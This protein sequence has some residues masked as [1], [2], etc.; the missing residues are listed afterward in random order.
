MIRLRAA[1]G[2]ARVNRSS[3]A[4]RA[5]PGSRMEPGVRARRALSWHDFTSDGQTKRA[6]CHA[7]AGRYGINTALMMCTM[8][9][10]A[11]MSVVAIP[12]ATSSF[13]VSV[14]PLSIAY[15]GDAI[16]ERL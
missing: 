2:S 15:C 6:R 10:D 9:F 14:P 3:R 13:R 11:E 5:M 4:N 1:S 8:P 16:T 7:W 12:A